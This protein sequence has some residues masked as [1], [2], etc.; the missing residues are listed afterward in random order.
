MTPM[1]RAADQIRDTV[2]QMSAL[3]LC[4]RHECC[5]HTHQRKGRTA[6]GENRVGTEEAWCEKGLEGEET[7]E[8][9]DKRKE[10]K[11]VC[12]RKSDVTRRRL[13]QPD[14]IYSVMFLS[15]SNQ[16]GQSMTL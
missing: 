14:E 6:K 7:R 13:H 1:L 8:E 15:D 10:R 16:F 9:E 11:G 4:S 5:W 2:R 3:V 12:P